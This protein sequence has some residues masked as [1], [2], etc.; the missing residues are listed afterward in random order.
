VHERKQ[1]KEGENLEQFG[2]LPFLLHFLMRSKIA[3]LFN[4]PPPPLLLL[5]SGLVCLL[6]AGRVL[7]LHW[8]S[9]S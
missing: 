8:K 1:E 7:S 6:A 9:F 2:E 3:L 5:Y 4:P